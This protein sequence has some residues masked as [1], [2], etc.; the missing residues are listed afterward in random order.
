MAHPWPLYDLRLRTPR[1][2]LRLPTEDELLRLIPVIDAGIHDPDV[3]PF[4]TAW[5]RPPSPVRERRM[6][7]WHW[8][9][10]GSWQ[11]DHWTLLLL[12][13]LDGEPIGAQDVSAED[14]AR[15]RVVTTGSW[16]GQRFQ[17][18]GIGTEMRQAVLHLAFAG[19]GAQWATS[20]FHEGNV[21]SARVSEKVGYS[22]NGFSIQPGEQEPYRLEHVII[23]RE[24]WAERRRDDIELDGLGPCL[25]LFGAEATDPAAPIA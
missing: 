13:F 24:A 6:L 25:E 23:G 15:L 19:L 1:L 16:I 14:F 11:P 4:S 8:S 18:R 10:R 9:Q 3:M 2:E 17:G 20:G 12:V 22:R 21:A 7:Q 5:T